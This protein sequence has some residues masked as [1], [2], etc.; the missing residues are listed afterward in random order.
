M[1]RDSRD[2]RVA[3]QQKL[4]WLA[5]SA[6]H[7]SRRVELKAENLRK[8]NIGEISSR[9]RLSNTIVLRCDRVP[10]IIYRGCKELGAMF[11]YKISVHEATKF[12]AHELFCGHLAKYGNNLCRL[13]RN[14]LDKINT[15]QLTAKDNLM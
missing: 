15:I 2:S 11:S 5:N 9:I 14:L 12:S 13:L 1:C 10:Q 8:R 4:S 3:S 7:N 6:S